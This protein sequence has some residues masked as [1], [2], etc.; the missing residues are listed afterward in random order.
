MEEKTLLQ[1]MGIKIGCDRNISIIIDR[2]PK[3][4]PEVAGEGI[5]YTWA[6]SKIYMRNVPINKRRTLCQF[7]EHVRLALSRTDGVALEKNRIRKFSA[8]ARDFIT[9]YHILHTGEGNRGEAEHP[10]TALTKHDIEKMHKVYWLHRG[11]L[12]GDT[13]YCDA[14]AAAAAAAAHRDIEN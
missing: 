1:H 10:H 11:M 2:T 8:R 13:A 12:E 6:M 14:A 3:C 5:E 7:H 9:V 4:H